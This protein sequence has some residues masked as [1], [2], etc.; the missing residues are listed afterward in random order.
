MKFNNK[1]E[2]KQN[3]K[4]AEKSTRACVMDPYQTEENIKYEHFLKT[5]QIN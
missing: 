4:T 1:I 5:E 3:G 2:I